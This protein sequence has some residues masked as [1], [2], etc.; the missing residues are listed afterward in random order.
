MARGRRPLDITTDTTAMV[1]TVDMADMV[2]M[3]DTDVVM[4]MAKERQSQAITVVAIMDNVATEVMVDMADMVDTDVVMAMAKEKQSQAIT[5]VAIMDT[6][7]TEAMADMV[8]TVDMVVM[9][10]AS[11]R[12][13]LRLAIIMVIT[14]VT[15]V[16]MAM[17]IMA[18]PT[19]V[20]EFSA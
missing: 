11:A 15:M 2:D 6:V 20:Q 1:D 10:M 4:A 8:D 9:A 13:M 16:D 18:R 12:L 3:A 17:A 14:R 5:V 19:L 7:A